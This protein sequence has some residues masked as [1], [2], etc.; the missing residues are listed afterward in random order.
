M[1]GEALGGD[2]SRWR[3][4]QPCEFGE[5]SVAGSDQLVVGQAP[6]VA[7]VA[8]FQRVLQDHLHIASPR[9]ARMVVLDFAAASEQV[10]QTALMARGVE[11]AMARG[12]EAAIHHPPVAHEHA[13][14]IV[15]QDGC[16]AVEPRGREES[17]RRRSSRAW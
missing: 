16:G 14:E 15:S 13:V 10:R 2:Q 7:S 17:R 3:V 12:V 5:Q 1:V 11:A 8:Q 9:A 4:D 6:G